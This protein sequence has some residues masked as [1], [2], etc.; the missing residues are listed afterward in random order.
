MTMPVDLERALIA[1]E[2]IFDDPMDIVNDT[3]MTTEEKLQILKH[4]EANAHDLQVA[5]EEG[6]TGPGRPRLGEVKKAILQLCAE[7]DLDEKD[8]SVSRNQK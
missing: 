4:W 8:I 1:P 5:T 7:T 6:M 3:H 2:E